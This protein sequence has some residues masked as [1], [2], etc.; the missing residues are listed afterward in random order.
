MANRDKKN[1]ASKENS[2]PWAAFYP[3]GVPHEINPDIYE[4][5]VDLLEQSFRKFAD[6]PCFS[7]LGM[8]L[9]FRQIDRLSR[10]FAAYLQSLPHLHKGDRIAIQLPNIL[11][12]PIAMFGALRAGFTVVNT[13]PLYTPR[14]MEFQFRDSGVKAIII[15]ANFARNLQ[16]IVSK[17][18]IQTIVVTEIADML[19]FPKRSLI[20]FIIKYIKRM[21]PRFRFR[22]SITFRQA[23]KIGNNREFRRVHISKTDLAFIQYTGGTTGVSKGAM[24]EHRNII[25]NMEQVAGVMKAR[26][27]EGEEVCITPLPLYHIFSL[28]VNCMAFFK[29][30]ALNVLITN[31]RDIPGF[32]KEL[33]KWKFTLMTGVNTLFN[34]LLNQKDFASL[35]FSHLKLV[36]GGAMAVQK[37]VAERWRQVTGSDL[38]EGYGLTEASP[39][40]CVNPPS[41]KMIIGTVG[42][43]IP[44]TEIKFVDE[45]GNEVPQG[46]AGEVCVRGPQVMK[47]YWQKPEET[48]NVLK[49]GWLHTG[50]LGMFTPEFFVKIVDRQKDMIIVSGFKVYPNEVEEVLASHPK[51]LEAGVIGVP[52]GHS[53]EAVKAFI[54]KKDPSLTIEEVNQHTKKNLTNYKVP[55]HIQFIESLPKTNVGKILRRELR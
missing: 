29:Y 20:N 13:N 16:E 5:A 1:T 51:I 37:P 39:V 30:G 33:R 41:G 44:S 36:V 54:V 26:L 21:V 32:V 8:T 28:V 27:K 25:A 34:A 2:F 17:T 6:K 48:K 3:E 45:K 18:Y 7:N 35:D 11:Q 50:D 40:V 14:E 23:L 52:D 47:G 49:D 9:T 15:G 24:L 43:P 12:F 55:K 4:S 53:G 19:S 38:L 46:T 22:E 10:N 42:I 31:P